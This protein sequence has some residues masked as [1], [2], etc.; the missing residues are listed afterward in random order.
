M[1]KPMHWFPHCFYVFWAQSWK[2][3]ALEYPSLPAMCNKMLNIR[4]SLLR[5]SI[6]VELF[7][8]IDLVVRMTVFIG[9][10]GR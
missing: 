4:S 9:T 1:D 2:D 7:K 3:V 8:F 5:N 6:M 10:V